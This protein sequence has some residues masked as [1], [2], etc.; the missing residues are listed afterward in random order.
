MAVKEKAL[1]R[2]A[3]KLNAAGV[4]WAV[5]GDWLLTQLGAG[6]KWHTFQLYTDYAHAAAADK[7]LTRLG[8]KSGE[9]DDGAAFTCEYHF[10]GADI[11][12]TAGP[13]VLTAPDGSV[14]HT[15]FDE[16]SC[17]GECTVLGACVH[18]MPAEDWLVYTAVTGRAEIAERLT[19]LLREKGCDRERFAHAVAEPLPAALTDLINTL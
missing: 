9:K 7:V 14:F 8:M 18:L 6:E 4:P 19:A 10:D 3:E 2:L 17:A 16:G 1:K 15:A 12:L 13:A 5:G 11:A